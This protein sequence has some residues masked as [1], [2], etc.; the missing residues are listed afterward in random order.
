MKTIGGAPA[1]VFCGPA[2]ATVKVAGTTYAFSGGQCL[3]ASGFAV[4]VGTLS[5]AS[6]AKPAY[7]GSSLPTANAGTDAGRNV[8][9]SFSAGGQRSSL[10]T[11]GAKVVV[12]SRLRGGSFAGKD[13][14]G[15]TVTGSFAC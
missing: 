11:A 1:R 8:T 14:A 2:K 6:K 7:F 5:F 4:N 12:R 9:L 3:K 13:L 10:S 15:R